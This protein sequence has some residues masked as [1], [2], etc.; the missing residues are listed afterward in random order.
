MADVLHDEHEV[1]R[2][3]IVRAEIDPGGAQWRIGGE[4]PVERDLL[5]IEPVG[6]RDL[7]CRVDQDRQLHDNG[8]RP[9][10]IPVT[11]ILDGQPVEQTQEAY[12]DPDRLHR[13]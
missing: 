8:R 6:P 12:T 13:E 3:D 4:R 9:N 5:L 1:V 10:L 11:P 2:V 7:T